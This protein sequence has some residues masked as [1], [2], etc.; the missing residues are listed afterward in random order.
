MD[1]AII[2]DGGITTKLVSKSFEIAIKEIF[3]LSYL[4]EPNKLET[5]SSTFDLCHAL[6]KRAY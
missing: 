4:Y 3:H 6:L 1:E 5:L 2:D